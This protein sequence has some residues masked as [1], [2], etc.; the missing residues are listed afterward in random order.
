M[1][2]AQGPD[3]AF[4]VYIMAFQHLILLN[5]TFMLGALV[6]H[7]L[8]RKTTSCVFDEFLSE[9]WFLQH[10]FS[11]TYPFQSQCRVNIIIMFQ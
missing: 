3:P 6:I 11:E 9:P 8:F 4:V 5:Q 10:F 7:L 1:D 2:S